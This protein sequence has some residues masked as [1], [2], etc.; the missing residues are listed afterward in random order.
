[1]RL[2]SLREGTVARVDSCLEGSFF[3]RGRPSCLPADMASED[4]TL[5]ALWP[6]S[7]SICERCISIDDRFEENARKLYPENNSTCVCVYVCIYLF[8]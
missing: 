4:T 2:I 1:M 7:T 8:F 3:R 5:E 6:L